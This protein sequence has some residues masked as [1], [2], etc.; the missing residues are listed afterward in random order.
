LKTEGGR[1]PKIGVNVPWPGVT[2]LLMFG[3][4]RQDVKNRKKI[5]E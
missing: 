5:A 1:K 2:S 3:S 4:K